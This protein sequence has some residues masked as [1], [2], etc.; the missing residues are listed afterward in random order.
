LSFPARKTHS[1]IVHLLRGRA[2]NLNNPLHPSACP[3]I[4]PL[5]CKYT[6]TYMKPGLGLFIDIGCHSD[7]FCHISRHISRAGDSFVDNIT[8][9]FK[10]GDELENKVRIVED[11]RTKK[12]IT[13]SLQSERLLTK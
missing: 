8:D 4:L 9:L 11:D 2:L 13:V 7:A 6:D 1:I 3:P 5:G 12:R 10:V